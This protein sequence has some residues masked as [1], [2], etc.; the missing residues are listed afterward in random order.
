MVHKTASKK[1]FT[2]KIIIHNDFLVQECAAGL[3]SHRSLHYGAENSRVA[4]QIYFQRTDVLHK[5]ICKKIRVLSWFVC[6]LQISRIYII[7]LC[8]F[9]NN[10]NTLP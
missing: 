5:H 10:V 7:L 9:C 3:N 6:G 8:V 2:K 4:T 1:I